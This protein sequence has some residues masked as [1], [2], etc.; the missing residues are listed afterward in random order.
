MARP[1]KHSEQWFENGF[2][3]WIWSSYNIE[4]CRRHH[5]KIPEKVKKAFEKSKTWLGELNDCEYGRL[6]H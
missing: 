5:K 2:H 4:M 6:I 3:N 1:K